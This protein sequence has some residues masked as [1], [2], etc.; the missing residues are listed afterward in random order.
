[1]LE[2]LPKP[3]KIVLVTP[4]IIA[5]A[6][7]DYFEGRDARV[8]CDALFERFLKDHNPYEHLDTNFYCSFYQTKGGT[9]AA[10]MSEFGVT[11]TLNPHM[12]HVLLR[13]FSTD[14]G[15]AFV[16]IPEGKKET[17]IIIGYAHSTVYYV[18]HEFEKGIRT[19][20]LHSQPVHRDWQQDNPTVLVF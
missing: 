6:P 10:I 14:E 13:Y 20:C 4:T 9:N 5:S 8:K 3:K 19:V 12:L 2:V 18:K 7:A 1:M 15:F 16:Q 17:S 11:S